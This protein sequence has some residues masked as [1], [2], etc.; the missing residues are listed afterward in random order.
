MDYALFI[1]LALYVAYV[2]MVARSPRPNGKAVMI[3]LLVA[4]ALYAALKYVFIRF[5]IQPR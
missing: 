4:I 1:S 3:A 2:V 5:D